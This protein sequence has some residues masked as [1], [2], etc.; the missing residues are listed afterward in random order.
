M[1]IFQFNVPMPFF[2]SQ[3]WIW[4]ENPYKDNWTLLHSLDQRTLLLH[5]TF[6]GMGIVINV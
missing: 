3:L 4:N 6:F 5:P 2:V 1:D